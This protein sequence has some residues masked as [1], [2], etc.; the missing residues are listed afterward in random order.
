LAPV[1]LTTRVAVLDNVKTLRFSWA[2]LEGGIT[3]KVISGRQLYVG[4]GQRP[5]TLTYFITLNGASLSKDMAQRCVPVMV[6]RP[7]Y[8]ATWE[9]QT[10]R[11]IETRR[12]EIIGDIINLLKGPGA[13]LNRFSRWSMWERAVLSRVGDP[14][15]CQRVIEERQAAIDDD[16]SQADS[17]REGFREELHRRGHCPDTQIV[18]MPSKEAA[19]IVNRVENEERRP[20]N[21]AMTHLYMLG[22]PEIRR[23]NRGGRGCVWT[24]LRADPQAASITLNDVC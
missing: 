19:A 21:R 2:E 12:W 14:A 9:E 3:A 24:G 20:F 1:A 5:N 16:Q 17:V 4:E 15:E 8:Q 23:S 6:K 7:D 13:D 11:L 10:I 18:W 22:I